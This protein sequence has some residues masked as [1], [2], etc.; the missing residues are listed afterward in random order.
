M[1]ALRRIFFTFSCKGEV[2]CEATA[3]GSFLRLLQ[4]TP[5]LAL[6]LSGGGK[7]P[8]ETLP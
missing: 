3:R 2:G 8:G 6:P 7:Y 5:S 1:N 4:L